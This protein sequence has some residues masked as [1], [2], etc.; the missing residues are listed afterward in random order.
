[1]F[2][3]LSFLPQL[4]DKPEIKTLVKRVPELEKNV[5]ENRSI[6]LKVLACSIVF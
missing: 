1:M 4:P 2:Q 3:S 5:P 6:A